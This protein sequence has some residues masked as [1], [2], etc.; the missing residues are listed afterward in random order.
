MGV[1]MPTGFSLMVSGCKQNPRSSSDRQLQ[2][3]SSGPSAS[4]KERKEG[5]LLLLAIKSL[6]NSFVLIQTYPT[7]LLT[8]PPNPKVYNPIFFYYKIWV[9][10][11]FQFF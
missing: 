10:F 4:A 8:L 6:F 7:I 5:G 3:K 9:V 11:I 1:M 2:Q